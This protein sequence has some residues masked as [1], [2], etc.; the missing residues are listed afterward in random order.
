MVLT[1]G[2][3]SKSGIDNYRLRMWLAED[4]LLQTGNYEVRL[5]IHGVVR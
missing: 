5:D 2:E 1:T 3:K 4:S